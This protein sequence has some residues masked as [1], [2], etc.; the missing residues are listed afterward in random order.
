ME[1]TLI[2]LSDYCLSRKA[3]ITFIDTL[4]EYG[5]LH[6]IIEQEE[7]YIEEDQLKDLERFSN[8]YYDLDVNPAGIEV[9]HH[10][11][12]KVEELQNEL[13]RLKN[14]LKSWDS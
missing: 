1:R 8:W 11:I 3:E 12:Q 9:A 13:Y 10:L 7:K 5:L 6:I 2:K 14:Q 4:N